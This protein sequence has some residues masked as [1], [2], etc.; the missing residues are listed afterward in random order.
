MTLI[1]TQD[2]LKDSQTS[3]LGAQQDTVRRFSQEG[4][5]RKSYETVQ[6]LDM[7]ESQSPALLENTE[8]NILNDGKNAAAAVADRV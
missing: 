6:S 7:V 3:V 1:H 2:A 8:S 5:L 4:N